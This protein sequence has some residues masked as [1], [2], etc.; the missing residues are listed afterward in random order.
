MKFDFSQGK[1]FPI[2]NEPIPQ[3]KV[4]VE[5]KQRRRGYMLTVSG[6]EL[7]GV[8]SSHFEEGAINEALE[9][10]SDEGGRLEQLRLELRLKK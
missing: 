2:E 1:P 9:L 3:G 5:W 10:Y 8:R 6:R 4:A 7:H